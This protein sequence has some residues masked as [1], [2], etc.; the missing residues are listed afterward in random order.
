MYRCLIKYEPNTMYILRKNDE[1]G[2][3]HDTPLPVEVPKS[4]HQYLNC[5]NKFSDFHQ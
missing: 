4:F 3:D 2:P 5:R 1:H